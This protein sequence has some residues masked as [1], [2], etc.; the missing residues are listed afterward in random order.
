LYAVCSAGVSK[1]D[2][3]PSWEL[4]YC[5]LAGNCELFWLA[6][7]VVDSVRLECITKA[8]TEPPIKA[9]IKAT[10]KSLFVMIM[11]KS[12]LLEYFYRSSPAVSAMSVPLTASTEGCLP[13]IV[14]IRCFAQKLKQM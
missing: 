8:P 13:M 6:A 14:V 7:W 4:A 1:S 9:A 2:G 12:L 3:R 11:V 10:G 5:A